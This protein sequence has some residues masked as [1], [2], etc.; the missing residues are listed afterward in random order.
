M[1]DR[2][3]VI[4]NFKDEE[5]AVIIAPRNFLTNPTKKGRVGKNTT[6]GG[7]IPFMTG[8]DYCIAKEIATKEREYHQ[9]K[10]QDKPF[11]QMSRRNY[12]GLFNKDMDMFDLKDHIKPQVRTQTAPRIAEHERAFRPANPTKKGYNGT[13]DK[14]PKYIENPPRNLVRKRPV[15]GEEE[16]PRFK[17]TSNSYSRPT[18]SIATSMKNMRSS[19][20]SVFRR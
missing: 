2:T 1:T 8:D 6:F 4:K 10:L 17:M 19:F 5:G 16:K 13:I 20:P 11:S 14:F 18:P 12:K 7:Q 3:T 9:S 15:E